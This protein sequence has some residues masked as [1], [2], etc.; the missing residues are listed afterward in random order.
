MTSIA[1]LLLAAA[2]GAQAPGQAGARP[3]ELNSASVELRPNES[4]QFRVGRTECCYVFRPEPMRV[5]WSIEPARDA[6]IDV[7]TG[8]V[9]VAKTA[10]PGSTFMVRAHLTDRDTVL[11][12]VVTVFTRA[13]H[14]LVGTWWEQAW[15]ACTPMATQGLVQ[16]IR[17]LVFRADGTFTVTWTP[18][19]R[20]TDYW[21]RYTYDVSSHVIDL[22][23]DHGNF[24]PTDFSGHGSAVVSGDTLRLTRVQL[25][26]K[27]AGP[28][29][30]CEWTF[31]RA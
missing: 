8:L 18:F 2:L 25:G 16:P 4:F 7:S 12:A 31:V 13:T 3:W 30:K 29:N 15:K 21:G 5:A 27:P 10:A 17:E 14:P 20:Y 9:I 11:T 6:S 22:H 24:V 1:A 28:S 26:T 19:E 23:L